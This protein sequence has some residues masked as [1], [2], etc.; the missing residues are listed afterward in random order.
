MQMDFQAERS[1]YLQIAEQIEDSILQDALEE[2]EQAPSTNQLADLYR[3][4]PATAGKGIKLLVDEGILIKRRG[5]GMFV[6]AGAREQIRRKRRLL[7]AD[8]YILPLLAEAGRL[9]I[10]PKEI[11]ALIEARQDD[12]VGGALAGGHP[13]TAGQPGPAD[14]QEPPSME[15]AAERSEP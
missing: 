6:A 5:I 11:C 13:V 8:T 9:G 1:I 3:I 12:A 2:E 4:N 14:R 15:P 10:R 7:F